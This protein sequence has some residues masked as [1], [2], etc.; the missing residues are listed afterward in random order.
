VLRG[1]LGSWFTSQDLTPSGLSG[2]SYTDS[3]AALPATNY[4]YKVMQPAPGFVQ[5]LHT[6]PIGFPNR[7]TDA[8]TSGPPIWQAEEFPFGDIYTQS[9]SSSTFL[10]FPGQY[11]ESSGAYENRWRFYL[12]VLGRYSQPDPLAL[13][14]VRQALQTVP[15]PNL[16]AY[17]R[18][19][20]LTFIDPRGLAESLPLPAEP[21]RDCNFSRYKHCCG[22]SSSGARQ[23]CKK[24]I[25]A[26]CSGQKNVICCDGEY[27]GCATCKDPE[28]NDFQE[29]LLR[30]DLY[31]L[32]C[33]AG[34]ATADCPK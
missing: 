27:K 23:C 2:T 28:A 21:T 26:A 14:P 34:R 11:D 7:I 5:Y 8:A 19:N 9:G 12:P 22:E 10:R 20:P 17:A 29:H 33:I 31:Q 18:N 24:I 30:C 6:S 25:D 4:W 1:T 3:G 16:F 32:R 15:A 13:G